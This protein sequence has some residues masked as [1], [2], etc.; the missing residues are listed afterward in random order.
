[1]ELEIYYL[2]I[3]TNNFKK[4]KYLYEKFLILKNPDQLWLS[5][6]LPWPNQVHLFLQCKNYT[7]KE[8]RKIK[9]YITSFK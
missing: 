7:E 2:C 3:V 5:S 4:S 9:L 6:P 8:K 1:M